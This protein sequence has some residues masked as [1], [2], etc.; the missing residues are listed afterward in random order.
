MSDVDD[1]SELLEKIAKFPEGTK[2]KVRDK[3]GSVKW[4]EPDG[5]EDDDTIL[6]KDDGSPFHASGG[7]AAAQNPT[8]SK[9]ALSAKAKTQKSV[10]TKDPLTYA[11]RS[12]PT[13]SDVLHHTMIGLSEE[14][15]ELAKERDRYKARG[16][17]ICT[18]SARRVTALK[19]VGDLY[20]KRVDQNKSDIIDLDSPAFKTLLSYLMETVD[21]AIRESNIRD[22]QREQIFHL[23][24]VKIDDKWAIEARRRMKKSV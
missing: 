19:A 5:I 3:K 1:R 14:A 2:F 15:N 20:L 24:S 17:N 13:S 11:I 4:R 16:K 10:A 9:A 7:Q 18:L 22:E 6:T 21:D 8:S 12:S 23:L